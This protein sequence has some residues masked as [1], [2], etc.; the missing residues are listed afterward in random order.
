[1]TDQNNLSLRPFS[2]VGPLG[3]MAKL[4]SKDD[5]E[6]KG[7]VKVRLLNQLESN[8]PDDKL[9]WTQ[10]E[11]KTTAGS[12]NFE[13]GK[14]IIGQW[15]H[16]STR[17]DGQTISIDKVLT[18]PGRNAD[19]NWNYTTLFATKKQE[20]KTP[21]KITAGTGDLQNDQK[22]QKEDGDKSH[23]DTGRDVN[24][25]KAEHADKKPIGQEK[26]DNSNQVLDFIKKIDPSNSS[27][28]VQPAVDI[29]KKLLNNT[30][31]LNA[32][33]GMMGGQMYGIMNQVMGLINKAGGGGGGN[34][35]GVQPQTP[36]SLIDPKTHVETQGTLQY[37]QN[38][39]L[40]CVP[41]N[42]DGT[43]GHIV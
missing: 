25:G 43:P 6:K 8:I 5:P 18:S 37:N 16:V 12:G 24:N 41:N 3:M 2:S 42:P 10:P 29:M 23:H 40:V 30:D 13:L 20:D 19:E 33:K 38:A 11:G 17:D 39:V 4:V 28:A 32:L 22:V 34:N 27:G 31:P 14:W 1:M 7:R 26:Y 15:F 35:G 9:P 36:C 21:K